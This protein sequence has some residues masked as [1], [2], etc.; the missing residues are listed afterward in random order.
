MI[1]VNNRDKVDWKEGMTA[2]DV[3]DAMGYDFVLITI[4]V[5]DQYVPED[6]YDTY[7]VPDDANVAIIHI[8][9]GG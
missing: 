1:L 3:M 8:H 9:H 2:Q 5:N 6:E 7:P 4:H